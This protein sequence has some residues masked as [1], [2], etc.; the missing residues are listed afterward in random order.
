MSGG[1]GGAAS[2]DAPYPDCAEDATR[3]LVTASEWAVG[4]LKGV[5]LR[6]DEQ[7]P[8]AKQGKIVGRAFQLANKSPGT[9]SNG[10]SDGG[11]NGPAIGLCPQRETGRRR[12]LSPM[13]WCSRPHP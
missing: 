9:C 7:E 2:R 4:R 11:V 6:A 10:R 12:S 13:P 5:N 8:L 3:E 1:V